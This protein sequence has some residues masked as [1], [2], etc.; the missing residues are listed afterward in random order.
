[1]NAYSGLPWQNCAPFC[2]EYEDEN[3]LEPELRFPFRF[4]LQL[5]LY[6][7]KFNFV[8]PYLNL[9]M[10]CVQTRLYAACRKY[11]Q[12]H[13]VTIKS[14]LWL[15]FIHFSFYNLSVVYSS[16][17]DKLFS[18]PLECFCEL[19]LSLVARFYGVTSSQVVIT[20]TQ[21]G[22]LGETRHRDL[23]HAKVSLHRST[24]DSR[25]SYSATGENWRY[26]KFHFRVTKW[27]YLFH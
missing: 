23:E 4:C 18:V 14:C 7:L 16:L 11:F 24:T 17:K 5:A 20:V 8:Y 9:V 22:D 25:I 10:Y 3:F 6:T 27:K 13:L 12:L 15:L 21:C 19:K 2:I 1:M 26:L